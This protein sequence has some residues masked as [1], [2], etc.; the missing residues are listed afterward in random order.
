MCDIIW[1]IYDI[2]STHS[3]ITPLYDIT[4]H[5][6]HVI[7]PSI[8]VIASTV[9]ASLLTGI[10]YPHQLSV[11]HQTHYTYD[12]IW[13]L[14]DTTPTLY[15]MKRLCSWHHTHFIWHHSHWICVVILLYRWHHR[16]YGCHHSSPTCDIIQTLHDITSTLYDIAPLYDI[17]PTLFMLSHPDCLTSHSM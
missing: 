2:T 10:D 3:Y 13:I 1:T 6:V 16:K 4:P 11:W 9:A 14:Y 5:S 7:T 8:S 17:T 15:D 12:I